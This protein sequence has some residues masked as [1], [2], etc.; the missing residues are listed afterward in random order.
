[1]YY[2]LPTFQQTVVM[3]SI[4]IEIYS[5]TQIRPP[6][7]LPESG[8]NIGVVLLMEFELFGH[9]CT[10]QHD[11]YAHDHIVQSL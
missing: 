3:D 2:N 7:G 5:K 1:M 10:V 9:G 6:M 11:M 4:S 8:L